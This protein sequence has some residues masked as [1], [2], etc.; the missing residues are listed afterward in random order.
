MKGMKSAC[1]ALIAASLLTVA[2][3]GKGSPPSPP[4]V[5][6]ATSGEDSQV[7]VSWSNVPEVATYKI[8]YSTTSGGP[9]DILATVSDLSYVAGGLTNGTTYY[10]VVTTFNADGTSAISAEAS[11]TPREVTVTGEP[12]DGDGGS[13]SEQ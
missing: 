12:S 4:D 1:L 2:A 3:C 5:V 8:Y 11:A 9:Y 10:F 6:N 7:T 13:T